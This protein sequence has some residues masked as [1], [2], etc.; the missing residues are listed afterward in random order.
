MTQAMCHSAW[1]LHSGSASRKTAMPDDLVPGIATRKRQTGGMQKAICQTGGDGHS[2]QRKWGGR[3]PFFTTQKATELTYRD[4]F[5][6]CFQTDFT[7]NNKVSENKVMHNSVCMSMCLS[8]CIW[9]Q[10]TAL[11]IGVSFH[12]MR[13]ADTQLRRKFLYWSTK[14]I[15]KKKK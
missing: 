12:H 10:A 14:Q 15:L 8:Q 7:M 1:L 4:I 9:R 6:Q 2:W 5:V 13:P 11:G 3:R